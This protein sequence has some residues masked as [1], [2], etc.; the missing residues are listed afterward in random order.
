MMHTDDRCR[1][2]EGEGQETTIPAPLLWALLAAV[3]GTKVRLVA[4]GVQNMRLCSVGFPQKDR[5]P[6]PRGLTKGNGATL[7][8][9]P[10]L[11]S[12]HQGRS[13]TAA[14]AVV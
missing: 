6:A 9:G 1:Y 2:Q 5:K 3:W 10:V 8:D 7:W 12:Y 4:K 14:E 13:Y 11:H